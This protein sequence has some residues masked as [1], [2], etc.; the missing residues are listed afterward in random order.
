MYKFLNALDPI[1][2]KNYIADSFID[3][4]KWEI[5]EPVKKE[6]PV[7]VKI[8]GLKNVMKLPRDHQAIKYIASRK[9]PLENLKDLYYTDNFNKWVNNIIPMKLNENYDEPRI[10]IPFFDKEKKLFGVTGRS[11]KPDGLRYI[12]IMFDENERKIFGLDRV[13]FTKKYYVLEG[14]MDSFFL[15]NAIAMAGA[16]LD[17]KSLPNKGNAV[18]VMDNEPRNAEIHKRIE[19][20]IRDGF[21]VCIWPK[22]IKEKDVNNMVLAKIENIE[23]IIDKNTFKGLEAET[24]LASWKKTR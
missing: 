9:I 6:K 7:R 23:D 17:L 22:N 8:D 14:A 2:A 4:N 20:A 21:S 1:L 16:D 11:L 13:D 5:Q 10:V 18:I 19:K 15:N 12:T 24:V 3:K